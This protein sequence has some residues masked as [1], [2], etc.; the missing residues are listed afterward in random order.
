MSAELCKMTSP[1]HTLSS[2]SAEL[3][4]PMF[5]ALAVA[6]CRCSSGARHFNELAVDEEAGSL[7]VTPYLG[8][9]MGDSVADLGAGGGYFSVKLARAVGPKGVVFA[10][11][12]DSESLRFIDEHVKRAG[13]ENVETVLGTFEDSKLQPRSVDL[14]FVRNTFHDIQDRVAYFSRV[15]AALKAGGRIAIIDYDPKKL[16]ALRK[17]H[18]HYLEESAIVGEMKAAGYEVVQSNDVLKEQSFNIFSPTPEPP[19]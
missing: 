16:G 19:R 12:I 17:L 2:L 11:D 5:I 10:V 8:L 4:A 13:I 7:D 6:S 1:K 18:G 14:I 9:K 15:K 3:L